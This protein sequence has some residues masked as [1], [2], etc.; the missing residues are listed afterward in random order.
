[1]RTGKTN[2]Q[3]VKQTE[4]K[5]LTSVMNQLAYAGAKPW[6]L[7][8]LALKGGRVTTKDIARLAFKYKHDCGAPRLVVK[9]EQ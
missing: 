8:L 2:K 7:R 6:E 9:D 5:M 4:W 1:M 3:L